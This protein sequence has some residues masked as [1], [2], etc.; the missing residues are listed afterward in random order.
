MA[1]NKAR[2]AKN[3]NERSKPIFMTSNKTNHIIGFQK[4]HP[5]EFRKNI[6]NGDTPEGEE[7]YADMI[8]DD[9]LRFT[10]RIQSVRI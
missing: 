3:I 7:I 10:T 5:Y 2:I 4:L 1:S 6:K 9:N 8:P